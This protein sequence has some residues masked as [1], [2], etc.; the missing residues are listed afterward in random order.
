MDPPPLLIHLSKTLSLSPPQSSYPPSSLT[1]PLTSH[2]GTAYLFLSVSSSFPRLQIHSYPAIHWA[3]AYISN[4]P[5]PS[6]AEEEEEEAPPSALG[7]SDVLAGSAIR[8]CVTQDLSHVRTFLTLLSP[9]AE[10]LRSSPPAATTLPSCLLHGLSGTLYLLR[11][12]RHWVPSS[13]PLV[14]RYIVHVS[15]HLLAAPW[16][17][18]HAS[19]RGAAD[20]ELGTLTQLVVTTPPLAPRLEGKLSELLDLQRPDGSWPSQSQGADGQTGVKEEGE[21]PD[22]AHG[23][24]GLVVSLLSLRPFFP[25]LQGKIDEVVGRARDF[26]ARNQGQEAWG[27]PSLWYGVLGAA[28]AFPKGETRDAFLSLSSPK[29]NI[30]DFTRAADSPPEPPS[31]SGSVATSYDPG[32]AWMWAVSERDMPR[33]IFYNDI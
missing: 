13:A 15:D 24:T 5:T 31:S 32:A 20:G 6:R 21:R 4:I 22:F 33:M 26:L 1:G 11:L 12:I 2:T 16:S 3:R 25:S 28:L 19:P 9:I 29:N 18:P 14:S 23:A 17:C 30:P 7:L 27:E 8:A 10:S